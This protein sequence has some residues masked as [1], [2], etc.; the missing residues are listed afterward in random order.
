MPLA[1]LNRPD[2]R[3]FLLGL[4]ATVLTCGALTACG[5]SGGGDA[6]GDRGG[7]EAPPAPQDAPGTRG[8]RGGD[9]AQEAN[10]KGSKRAEMS[11]VRLAG[12]VVLLRFAGPRAPGYV[13]RALR[14]GCLLYTSP[15]P[16]DS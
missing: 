1:T 15:S 10:A 9:Q 8:Q 12:S 11:P 7:Q 13:L 6:R 4:T 2:R 5:G 16:R 3:R 14:K